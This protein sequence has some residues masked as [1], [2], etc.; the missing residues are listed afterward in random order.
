MKWINLWTKNFESFIYPKLPPVS[1]HSSYFAQKQKISGVKEKKQDFEMSVP[2][3]GMCYTIMVHF[4]GVP[5]KKSCSFS[6]TSEIFPFCPK[7]LLYYQIE[8]NF[9]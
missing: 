6:L 4:I 7:S 3:C 1:Y 2:S 9:V 5:I 8:G